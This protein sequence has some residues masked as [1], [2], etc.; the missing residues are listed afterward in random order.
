MRTNDGIA[1][2]ET[3]QTWAAVDLGPSRTR[4]FRRRPDGLNSPD[5]LLVRFRKPCVVK[6]RIQRRCLLRVDMNAIDFAS[7][8]NAADRRTRRHR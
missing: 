8:E 4:S 3:A 7:G 6:S 1:R 5:G 2:A